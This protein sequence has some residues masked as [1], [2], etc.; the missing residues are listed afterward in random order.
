MLAPVVGCSP[1]GFVFGETDEGGVWRTDG[2][3]ALSDERSA[4]ARQQCVGDGG[5][6][7]DLAQPDA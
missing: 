5:R 1:I 3:D 2:V 7:I 4:K 6:R